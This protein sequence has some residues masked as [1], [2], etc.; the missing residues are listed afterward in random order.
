MGTGGILD[1][2]VS[3]ASNRKPNKTMFK[4]RAGTDWLIQWLSDIIEVPV[5]PYFSSAILSVWL[6]SPQEGVGAKN[7]TSKSEDRQ[8]TKST[9]QM[10]R[11][12]SRAFPEALC[13]VFHFHS[14]AIHSAKE[15]GD[16][17][18]VFKA[19]RIYASQI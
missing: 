1:R 16:R 14:L 2:T 5:L 7:I 17:A 4:N 15:R 13:Q 12:L 3:V 11:P 10:R 8:R 9:C 6:P 18:Y 19:R